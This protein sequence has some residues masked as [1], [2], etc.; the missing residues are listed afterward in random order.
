[1]SVQFVLTRSTK[2]RAGGHPVRRRHAL[3]ARQRAGALRRRAVA[4]AGSIGI[5]AYEPADMTVTVEPGV[6]LAELQA[7]LAE[8]GQL[9]PLDPPCA[10]ARRSAA[11]WR[12]TRT[13]P[14]RHALRHSARLA[15]SA[16]ASCT[17]TARTSKSGGRVVKNVTGY[18][19][20]KL[21]VGALGTLGV[22]VEAT[23]K[24]AP[25]P[26]GRARRSR[27]RAH[28][29]RRRHRCRSRAHDAGLALQA[30]ESCSRLPRRDAVVGDARWY[31]LLARV[32]G[33]A[34]AVERTLRDLGRIAGDASSAVAD[35]RCRRRVAGVARVVRAGRAGA[36]RE[37]RAV[38]HVADV[39][40]MC[41]TAG[42]GVARACRRRLSCG[43]IRVV[44]GARERCRR[45]ARRIAAARDVADAH[46][47]SVVVDAAPAVVEAAD[48][49]V[50]P[51][52][53]RLRDHAAAEGRVRPAAD[54]LARAD[55]LGRL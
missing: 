13:G 54:A 16:R 23:F 37:R 1:M 47:G 30:L 28:P 7:R 50:R 20:H 24:L 8:H 5:I 45:A 22:I 17:R 42:C 21:H 39:D 6:R 4:R 43:L 15:A 31:V 25:L 3:G 55:S 2:C 26:E 19:M 51:A 38:E 18:D 29:P 36:A 10:A 32:A 41:S 49:R 40:A 27:S 12:R 46:G 53:R 11:C 52:A 14:L 34:A 35:E 48:R 33:G 9:L 44:H